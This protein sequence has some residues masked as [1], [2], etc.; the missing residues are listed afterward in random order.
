MLSSRPCSKLNNIKGESKSVL[1][2]RKIESKTVIK[3]NK[4]TDVDYFAKSSKAI[5]HK[6]SKIIEYQQKLNSKIRDEYN[7]KKKDKEN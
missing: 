4:A 6:K 2:K 1:A 5:P 7:I 3:Q